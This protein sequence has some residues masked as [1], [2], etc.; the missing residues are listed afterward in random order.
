MLKR[1]VYDRLLEWKR[2]SDA[3]C[4]LVRGPRQVGKTFI[5]EAFGKAEYD[6]YVYVNFIKFPRAK[7]AFSDD[8]DID[9]IMAELSLRLRDVRY[10]PGNTLLFLDEIQECPLARTALKMFALDGRYDVIASGSL[11][12]LHFK[13]AKNAPT[14]VGYEEIIEMRAMDFEEFLWAM[15]RDSKAVDYYRNA[16]RDRRPL[17]AS[18][19]ALDDLFRDFTMVGG[20]PAVVEKFAGGCGYRRAWEM[21]QSILGTY[22]DDIDRYTSGKIERNKTRSCMRSVP[23]QLATPNRKFFYSKV[24]GDTKNGSRKF[25]NGVN[26]LIDAGMVLPCHRLTEPKAFLEENVD[27]D[28]FKVYMHDTGLL[29]SMYDFSAMELVF[30]EDA[31]VKVGAVTENC[32]AA[33]IDRAGKVPYYFE[34]KSKLEIDF[35]EYTKAGVAAIEV[36]SGENRTSKSLD[37]LEENGYK[38]GARIKLEHGDIWTDDDGILHLPLWAAGFFSDI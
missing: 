36:K 6:N 22:M 31:D 16:V 38:A 35:V 17:G 14:P 19:S 9:G 18:A 37:A 8:L 5:I 10:S 12:G 29:M 20:M 13:N 7:G 26:W 15:G 27:E 24:D 1:K 32:V 25:R 4:L 23:E 33:C 30:D 28:V 3:T 21:N 2:R 34:K 11:L